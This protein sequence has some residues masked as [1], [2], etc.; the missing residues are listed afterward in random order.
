MVSVKNLWAMPSRFE[1]V[2]EGLVAATAARKL[3]E[4]RQ[5]PVVAMAV[6]QVSHILPS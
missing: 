5:G 2:V 1:A 3:S 4:H 6:L